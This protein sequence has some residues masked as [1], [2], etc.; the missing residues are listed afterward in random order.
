LV[1][2]TGI[3]G[4][5]KQV[6]GI[7]YLYRR[8][9]RYV[10]YRRIPL[11]LV[12]KA[13]VTRA[14]KKKLGPFDKVSLGT[15][16][17]EDAK[18]RLPEEV[19]KFEKRME[20]IRK[21]HGLRP[22][23]TL[24][25]EQVDR[26]AAAWRRK[27]LEDLIADPEHARWQTEDGE[28]STR[29]TFV[30]VLT[31]ADEQG[32]D[33][34][35][36]AVAPEVDALLADEG[37]K[38]HHSEEAFRRLCRE[39][40]ETKRVALTAIDRLRAYERVTVAEFTADRRGDGPRCSE[41][42]A[43]WIAEKARG[44]VQKT[45]DEHEVWS[46]RFLEARGDRP[47]ST[48]RKQDGR[49][50]RA[51]LQKLPKSWTLHPALKGLG[52]VAAAEK[53]RSL[54]LPPM[55]DKNVNKL[56]DYVG[57]FWRWAARHYDEA[58][59]NPFAGLKLTLQT[60]ARD[61]RHPFTPEELR[62]IFSAPRFVGCAGPQRL[63]EPGA[64][65]PRD[66]GV[67]WVPLL[68][69]FSGARLGELVQLRTADVLEFGGHWVMSIHEA[70]EDMRLKTAHSARVVPVHPDLVAFG[71]L[72]FVK[73]RRDAQAE[74]L[75]PE[76]KKGE[77]GYYSS[78]FSKSFARW[79]RILGIK[80]R[81]NAFHSFRHNFID[82]R[83]AAGVSDGIGDALVGHAQKGQGARYGLAYMTPPQMAPL[84]EAMARIRY[85]GL[86]LDHLRVAAPKASRRR[87]S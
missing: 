32:I 64:Y 54:G 14:D 36:R 10:F 5:M 81:K 45:R 87:A 57:S 3:H 67:F 41:A 72:D 63:N 68:A 16:D 38:V 11:D 22:H 1:Y 23:D 40:L 53:A 4:G 85:E 65:V 47:L 42:I 59:P 17:F 76:L 62:T 39:L 26:F 80:D 83:R 49:E 24:T 58:P 60:T 15:N 33:G 2:M 75:F 9:A 34:A 66:R 86:N 55:S 82:A 78:P 25:A 21:A 12:G 71:F 20:T 46:Q 79:L 6:P 51:L 8:G 48:Y 73:T 84:V 44:W 29:D 18:R 19:V 37:V 28:H 30:E 56:V 74:R 69:L 61:E 13:D 77:D 35:W 70:A 7:S 52:I 50:F 31:D 27:T 43:A